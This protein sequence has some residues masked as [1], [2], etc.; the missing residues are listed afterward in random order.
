ML[1]RILALFHR[2]QFESELDA[3]LRDHLE[4]Y[5]DDLAS[6]GISAQ[7]AERRARRE[8]GRVIAVK[9]EVRES[10][11][12]A[13]A[14]AIARNFR[15]AF[16][17]L[18]KNPAFS[19][20][21]IVTLALCI[22]ANTAIFSIVDAMLFRPL[23]YPEPDRLARVSR[24]DR[25]P[26][27]WYEQVA[28]NGRT[29]EFIRDHAR[30]IDVAVHGGF[31][32]VNLVAPAG[33]AQYVRQVRVST[34][35]FRV[36]GVAPMIGREIAAEEDR[37][38]G[39]PVAVLSHGLWARLFASDAGILGQSI[40]LRGEPYTVV[41]VMPQGFDTTPA[42]E[43]WTPLRPSTRGEGGGMNY[44]MIVRLRPGVSTAQANAELETLGAEFIAENHFKIASMRWHLISVQRA[45]V[46]SDRGP[47]LLL[48]AAVGLVLLIGC[49][50]IAGLMLARG[51]ARQHEI[52]TRMALG[53]G[54]GGILAQLLSESLLLAIVGGTA[55]FALG[56]LA[57]EAL[58]PVVAATLRPT[59][60]I[61]MDVRVMIVTA[62]TALLTGLI[63]GFYPALASS[64]SDLLN[65]LGSSSRTASARG[66]AWARRGLVVCEVAL[67]MVLLV[68]AGLVLRPLIYLS[69]LN[70]GFDGRHVLT[71]SLSL[72]DA[73]YIADGA[74]NRLFDT[75]LAGI[76][77][78]PGVEAAGIGLTLP[79]E[80]ALNDGA[81]IMDGP[82]AM[83]EPQITDLLYVTPG[84]FEALR[85]T[86]QRG[87]M[88]EE[89]DRAGAPLVAIV[90]EAYV[91]HYLKNDDPLGRHL[92]MAGPIHEIVGVVAD[93]QQQSGWGDFGPVAPTP[94]V[95]VPAA[96]L[97]GRDMQT[98]DNYY[99]PHWVVRAAGPQ[100]G[101][102]RAMRSAVASV[103]RQLPFAEFRSMDEVRSGAFSR[104]RLQAVLLGSLA[105]LAL[106]LAAVG[107]YGLV[108]HSVMDRT[109]EFGIRLALGAPRWQAI[110][111]A[112]RPGIL[113]TLVGAG[114]GYFL[115]Q[116]AGRLLASVLWGVQ[117]DDR[118]AF[119]SVTALL[120]FV[121]ALAS[122]VPSLRI[123]RLD[124]ATTLREE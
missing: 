33:G 89:K 80:R 22:G 65:A 111:Q 1:R 110:G 85:F 106:V 64:R 61:T 82:N 78:T 87:R 112:A 117:P 77:Q 97:S 62:A 37:S 4:K 63:F 31:E 119:V 35:F 7:E 113:L 92:S 48:W 16:R 71:A 76:R 11:G 120:V 13:W 30:T 98:M 52:T 79:Y 60:P 29:W 55:G 56:S 28:V 26:R 93:V 41:G 115:A 50:N 66:N 24:L 116:G 54:R 94:T 72:K 109:R 90:N 8:F 43:L 104:Q 20:T 14:D 70:P 53:S 88:F 101:I 105:A 59:Q 83:T 47:I 100:T 17:V 49:V 75:S 23:P 25:S 95:Y 9:E 73:R 40:L 107:I 32:G 81:R 99:S 114:I 12:L 6:Q 68:S 108:A 96:Q 121:A 74:V 45:N 58:K 103:D 69:G 36:L 51:G 44:S 42:A 84:Y 38:G 27:G 2:T 18:R 118:T 57:I 46:D 123:A 39:P 5:R 19:L 86:K 91:R 67:G 3:E 122:L 34:G 21:V 10:S 15:Y 124:P 102:A